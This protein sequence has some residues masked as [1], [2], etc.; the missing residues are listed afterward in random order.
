MTVN[1]NQCKG[2]KW[3]NLEAVNLAHSHFDGMVGVYVIWH[4]G[5][6]PKTV[7]VGQGEIRDRLECHRT[8]AEI[9]HYEAQGLFVTWARVST[10]SCDGVECFLG[11]ELKPLVGDRF[12]DCPKIRVNLPW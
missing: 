5:T 3:C 11:E 1:W 8:D 7:R 4:G 9:L 6:S 12:P 2:D 10:D